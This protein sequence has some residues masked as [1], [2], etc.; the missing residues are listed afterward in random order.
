MLSKS[1][2]STYGLLKRLIDT[3]LRRYLGLLYVSVFFMALAAALTAAIAKLFQPVLDKVL[4]GGNAD[5]VFP[6]AGAVALTFIFRGLATYVHTVL[7]SRIGQS[8]VSDIQK[9]VF[10]HFMGMDM[11]F[12]HAH[13]SGQLISRVVND[14]SVMR[15]AVA[16][17]LTGFGKS[18]LTLVF[19]IGVMFYQDW[20]LASAALTIFPLAVLFV[21]RIGK[22][23]RKISGSIQTE[24]ATMS[25]RLSQ[26][27]Q[28]IRQVKAHNAEEFE[29]SRAG[30][31]IENVR[32]LSIK[33]ARIGGLSAPMNETLVGFSVFG[34]ILYGGSQIA[35]GAMTAGE[36]GSFIAAF[37]LAYEPMKRLARINNILQ[38]GLGAAERVFEMLDKPS[39]ILN[40]EEAEPF[41]SFCPE[42]EFKDVSFSYEDDRSGELSDMDQDGPPKIMALKNVSFRMPAGTV[43][44]LVGPSG[45]GK[46]TILNLIPRFY[47]PDEGEIRFD[48]RDIRD[49]DIHD[50][51]KH[52]SL[53]SQDIVIFDDT[54]KANIAYAS[55][56]TPF[57]D[58]V[59]AAEMAAAD[60]FIRG[61][62]K[63]YDTILGEN[64]V[65]LSGGQR[66][67][68]AIARAFLKNTPVLLLDE[69][70][71]A[72]D[73]ESEKLIQNSISCLQKGKT[74]LVIA[75]RLTTIQKA[76]QILVIDNGNIME[77]GTHSYLLE[78]GG[79][80]HKMARGN[81]LFGTA[82]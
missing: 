68:I 28:G 14:V 54:V 24:I 47:D 56:D 36:L 69:A 74:T 48:G 29:K 6:I 51:R 20:I 60:E 32:D 9:D 82:A 21:S 31:V 50:L 15:V 41:S 38:T 81:T 3:Y 73:S 75:H 45:G 44:A 65:K 30:S 13:S 71:S 67:R 77:Q 46:S 16:D 53:V 23:L 72:L 27:F 25:S 35:A 62:P 64:G 57:E 80:Y 7:L 2:N 79:L 19:L 4:V 33:S 76:D 66:Q 49:I 26:T 11:A 78:S 39:V 63:G 55:P 52:I 5:Y 42:I 70:T 8:V 61:M 34:V 1:P 58:I 37:I 18:F 12:F 43:T 10:N 17:C 22:R 59:N 40:R